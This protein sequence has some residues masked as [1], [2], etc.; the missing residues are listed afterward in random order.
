MGIFN[1][2][3]QQHQSQHKTSAPG[4]PQ[5]PGPQRNNNYTPANIANLLS[6]KLAKITKSS[7]LDIEKNLLKN[8]DNDTRPKTEKSSTSGTCPQDYHTV[9]NP[10]A[11]RLPQSCTRRSETSSMKNDCRRT[12]NILKIWILEVKGVQ[13]K[14]KYYCNVVVDSQL[15]HSTV[16][17]QKMKM[18]FWG[19]YFQIDLESQNSTVC[20]E[21]MRKGDK[22]STKLLGRVEIKL[23]SDTSAELVEKWYLV[24]PVKSERETPT[25]RIKYKFRPLTILPLVGYWDLREYLA[26]QSMPLCQLLEPMV[27]VKVKEDVATALVNISQVEGRATEFLV[28]LILNDILKIGEFNT[29]NE[30]CLFR[31]NSIATKAI[32]AYMRLVGE[33]YLQETLTSVVKSIISK[34]DDLEVDPMRIKNL[35][36]LPTVI[37]HN[38]S[39]LRLCVEIVWEVI[40]KSADNFPVELCIV[41][42]KIRDRL[43]QY[44]EKEELTDNLISACVFLRFLCPAILSPSLFNILQEYPEE[45]AGRHLTLVAKTIQTLANFTWFHRKESY[46]EFLNDFIAQE[47]TNCRNFLK[48]VS[49]YDVQD[50]DHLEFMGDI[51]LGKHLS[52]L[53]LQLVEALPNIDS[54]KNSLESIRV[55]TIVQN[56]STQLSQI[57]SSAIDGPYTPSSSISQSFSYNHLNYILLLNSNRN[58][59]SISKL[60]LHTGVRYTSHSHMLSTVTLSNTIQQQPPSHIQHQANV[61]LGETSNNSSLI[62]NCH[63]DLNST[64]ESR[65]SSKDSII[66]RIDSRAENLIT[67][68]RSPY[69]IPTVTKTSN[70]LFLN[71]HSYTESHCMALVTVSH[72]PSRPMTTPHQQSVGGSFYTTTS[73]MFE[74]QKEGKLARPSVMQELSGTSGGQ[75]QSGMYDYSELYSS[76]D[77]LIL[78]IYNHCM[79]GGNSMGSQSSISQLS[80]AASSGYQ[81]LSYS[82]SSSPI[83]SVLRS[84]TTTTFQDARNV[85]AMAVKGI[86]FIQFM[87]ISHAQH[88]N[89]LR[90]P[91]T[92]S[93]PGTKRQSRRIS[94]QALPL[95]TPHSRTKGSVSSSPSSFRSI[96]DLSSLLR[97]RL[98]HTQLA[99]SSSDAEND[100]SPERHYPRRHK[101]A[102]SPISSL[103]SASS[104][105][106]TPKGHSQQLKP[107]THYSRKERHYRSCD[108]DGNNLNDS[109]NDHCK[110]TTNNDEVDFTFRIKSNAQTST[111]KD[112][113]AQNSN[114][115]QNI[116]SAQE[117]Q[118]K[119]IVQRLMVM[120]AEFHAE[121]EV[122]R[123]ELQNKEARINAQA[124][125]IAEL[126]CVNNKMIRTIAYIS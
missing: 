30:Q 81:S 97:I 76:M 86:I 53:H 71:N 13:N 66:S 112:V 58:S 37:K 29:E 60:P 55:T 103:R 17:K 16:V 125:K 28:N 87:I 26:N 117:N 41:F 124:K 101:I 51:D 120:E 65:I 36:N 123:A 106:I 20:V 83:D 46:M 23:N 89:T 114:D 38:Q 75:T 19:E 2:H 42:Q 64:L 73:I 69:Q 7:K 14:K 70:K 126:D 118:M 52:L 68:N 31:G 18:C 40:L 10:L 82:Q 107:H 12:E 74:R 119:E 34:T 45:R 88:L 35:Q 115:S 47:Q 25:L 109:R 3:Q 62:N 15:R 6:R 122:M 113:M 100:S 94:L 22:K 24:K 33:Q 95:H 110:N 61:V 63:K 59:N 27:T 92:S 116:L 8:E 44:P 67:R 43:L 121:Q 4:L 32:E 56:I 78:H 93:Q 85:L 21:L 72:L 108:R 90:V 48:I 39:A 111:Q 104:S 1:D 57:P 91:R 98:R 5:V 11:L 96:E 105:S 50:R 77:S 102:K 54:S 80:N 84:E 49:S 9:A 79:D 99:S